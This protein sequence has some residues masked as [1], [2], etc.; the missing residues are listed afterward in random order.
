MHGLRDRGRKP[1]WSVDLFSHINLGS[2][3]LKLSIL[4]GHAEETQ[5]AGGGAT[6]STSLLCK[7]IHSGQ[8]RCFFGRSPH[9]EDTHV[10]IIGQVFRD[11]SAPC[12]D[13]RVTPVGLE[14]LQLPKGKSRVRDND[15]LSDTWG[16]LIPQE[17][18]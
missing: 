8:R 11:H 15:S 7:L 14:A 17:E 9:D 2:P 13:D 3:G 4:Q 18:V 5:G 10:R 16:R 6:P 1:P 12:D